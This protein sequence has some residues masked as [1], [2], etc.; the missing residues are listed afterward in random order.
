[1]ISVTVKIHQ[2]FKRVLS[3]AK[4]GAPFEVSLE[5]GTTVGRLLSEEIA[6]PK[7]VPKL[8]LVNGVHS[9]DGRELRN[10]DR[11][12]LFAPMAGG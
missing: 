8:V 7:E 2:A 10:G 4:T 11:V 5:E 6:F 3:Q 9:E 12:S 1:M